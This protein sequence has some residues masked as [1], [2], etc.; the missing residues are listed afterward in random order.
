MPRL[1]SNRKDLPDNS[2]DGD[3]PTDPALPQTAV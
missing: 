3:L 2:G 1:A